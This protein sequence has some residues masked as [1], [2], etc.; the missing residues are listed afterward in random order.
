MYKRQVTSSAYDYTG[1]ITE[2]R[3][4]QWVSQKENNLYTK[5]TYDHWNRPLDIRMKLNQG[6]TIVHARMQYNE[7]GELEQKKLHQKKGQAFLQNINY[8]YNIRGWLTNINDPA[9]LSQ[10]DALFGMT[11]YYHSPDTGV[12]LR[13]IRR[14]IYIC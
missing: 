12:I 7:T 10:N 6:D 11:L 3:Q 4:K 5:H 14:I 2:T 9:N 8:G 1:K 13:K